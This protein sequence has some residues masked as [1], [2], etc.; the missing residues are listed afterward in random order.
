MA[1]YQVLARKYRPQSFDE[2]LG[3][4]AIVTTLKNAIKMGRL[5]H[6]Y[7]FC[8][9][10]G[11]GKTTLARVF[12]K[13]LNC[14]NPTENYEP[15]NQCS[16]CKE[17]AAGNS[18]DVLEID[19]ASHRGI[20]DIRQINETVGYSSSS[21]KYKIYIIDEVHM[22]TKEAFNALLKTLEEPPAKVLFIFATTEPHKVLPTILSRCQR[23]N[24]SRIPL[25]NIIAKLGRIAKDM[26]VTIDEEALHLL[27]RRA[28]GG[29]RDAESLFDQIIAFHEGIITT[30]IVADVLGI[31]PNDSMF[32]LD[33]AG[34]E[35]NLSVA[36]EIAHQIFSQ[37]KDIGQFVES[38]T[39]HFR[40]LLLIKISGINAPF[41]MLSESDKPR[42]EASA[43]IYGQ[44]QCITILDFLVE[45][46][47]QIR[48]QTSPRIALE[49]ILLRIMRTHQRLPIEFLVR[50]LAELEQAI[51]GGLSTPTP[52]KQTVVIP[53]AQQ[54]IL[55]A[56][57]LTTI[58]MAP[59]PKVVAAAPQAPIQ[60]VPTPR[61]SSITVDPTPTPADL[62]IKAKP[63]VAE[64]PP[65]PPARPV[66]VPPQ[67]VAPAVVPASLS[68][69]QHRYDT[70]LQFAAVELEGMVQK[71]QINAF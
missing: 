62:G 71:K 18:L 25:E 32:I 6:A 34:K 10:R 11:T 4:P 17:I 2:V 20:D 30:E 38:I 48:F 35:G 39:E 27:A 61:T 60:S 55:P 45:A 29:L 69:K 12:A 40:T 7:L 64:M 3:Q 66:E 44:E 54:A 53:S 50:R 42:Y 23:F 21:G 19:G 56:P 31:M 22:L 58:S 63:K 43:K 68:H 70:I 24:L 8:G 57:P 67:K 26:N 47:N 14:Q 46:Q 37:G 52:A 16:S 59:P 28:D 15:C 1:A 5:A 36:F 13:A 9:S 65:M 33:Q 51:Q 49:A 41:L